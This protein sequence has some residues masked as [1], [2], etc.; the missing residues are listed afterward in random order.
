MQFDFAV[1]VIK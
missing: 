1:Q